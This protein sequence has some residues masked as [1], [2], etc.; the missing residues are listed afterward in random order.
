[1]S[2]HPWRVAGLLVFVAVIAVVVFIVGNNLRYE[3]IMTSMRSKDVEKIRQVLREE[4]EFA[5]LKLMPQGSRTRWRGRYLIH[6]AVSDG[7][8]AVVAT[9]V[10]FG[11]DL[12]VRLDGDSLLHIAADHARPEM[13]SWLVGKE[14]DVNDRNTCNGC[15]HEGWTPLHA[16]QQFNDGEGSEL[17]LSL[18]ADVNAADAMGRTPLHASA[19]DG[20]SGGAMI[21]CAHG[22]DATRRDRRGFTPYD[23]ARTSGA[24]GR[25]AH[26]PEAPGELAG[27]LHPG[28]GCERLAARARP[29]RPASRD[30]VVQVWREYVCGRGESSACASK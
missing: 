24:A 27:W 5:M 30:Y 19:V 22:A 18:G 2:V 3:S 4:P 1:M 11:A 29:D 23:L 13:I 15:E 10:E 26:V 21:L 20:S 7:N 14:A 25:G 12:K 28:G 8:V 16:A 6:E 9:L 17:L